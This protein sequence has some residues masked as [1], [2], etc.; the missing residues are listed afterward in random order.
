MSWTQRLAVVLRETGSCQSVSYG[1]LVARVDTVRGRRGRNK[2]IGITIA[3]ELN[4]A[5]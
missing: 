3:M 5:R 1:L 2:G 4:V